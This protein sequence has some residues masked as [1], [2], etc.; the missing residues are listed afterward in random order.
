MFFFFANNFLI[1]MCRNIII[2]FGIFGKNHHF[3]SSREMMYTYF[4]T[5]KNNAYICFVY[6]CET[7]YSLPSQFFLTKTFKLSVR[8]T[9][10]TF[11]TLKVKLPIEKKLLLISQPRTSWLTDTLKMIF[12]GRDG[13]LS[14]F[15]KNSTLTNNNEYKKL[16]NFA[17]TWTR[18]EVWYLAHLHKAANPFSFF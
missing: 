6:A 8:I 16:R 15:R 4:E 1:Y 5:K 3:Y 12:K 13:A 10:F 14:K 9:L 2:C 18:Q 17:L 11:L 7:F